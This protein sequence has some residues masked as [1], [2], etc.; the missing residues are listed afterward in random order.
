[1][2]MFPPQ[3]S[4]QTKIAFVDVAAGNYELASPRWTQTSDGAVA[5]VDMAV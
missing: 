1:M 3:N 2:P 4:L 5:G